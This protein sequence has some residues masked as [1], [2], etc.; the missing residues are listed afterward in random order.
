MKKQDVISI[1]KNQIDHANV[2]W[3]ES[4]EVLDLSWWK[5]AAVCWES[6]L[7]LVEK[8]DDSK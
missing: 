4:S 1:I 3:E 2:K 6:A 5:S 7:V 8:I